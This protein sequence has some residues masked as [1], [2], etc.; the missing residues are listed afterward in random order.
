M[1][2]DQSNHLTNFYKRKNKNFQRS[3]NEYRSGTSTSRRNNFKQS[4]LEKV[5]NFLEPTFSSKINGLIFQTPKNLLLMI[6]LQ[7]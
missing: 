3:T 2:S 5:E 7:I 4:W 1:V 6:K